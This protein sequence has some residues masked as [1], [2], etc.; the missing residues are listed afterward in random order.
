MIQ[1]YSDVFEEPRHLPPSRKQDHIIELFP[2]TAA[3]NVRHYRYPY[4]QKA[5]I[6]KIIQELLANGVIRPSVSHFSC[7]VLLLKKKDGTWR[8]WIDYRA[9]NATTVKDKYPIPVVDELIDEVH[10]AVVFTN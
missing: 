3:I 6:E 7:P 8:L 4:F 5:E 10:G 9:L 1:K 2:N